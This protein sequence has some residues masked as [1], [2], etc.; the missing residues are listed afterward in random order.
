MP[1][2]IYKKNINFFRII[3]FLFDQCLYIPWI[4]KYKLFNIDYDIHQSAYFNGPGTLLY[5]NGKIIIG[6]NSYIGRYSSI[7]ATT[8]Q[9]VRIGDNCSI[10]HFVKIYT[11]NTNSYDVMNNIRPRKE[12]RGDVIIGNNCWIGANVF[13]REGVVIGDCCV[14]GANSVVVTN[15]PSHSVAA[16]SPA[17]IIKNCN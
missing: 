10:S 16:G 3:D 5:G 2:N 12:S 8:E 4:I 11:N 1:S 6:K 9:T 13:I 17:R 15:I 7:Q 14:I